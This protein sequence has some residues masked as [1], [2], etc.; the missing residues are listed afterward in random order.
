MCSV[1]V[2]TNVCGH[3]SAAG[4]PR[5]HMIG[6]RSCFSPSSKWVLHGQFEFF[7]LAAVYPPSPLTIH[8]CVTNT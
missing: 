5:V 1:C 7:G 6:Y 3:A 8:P 4:L 2:C